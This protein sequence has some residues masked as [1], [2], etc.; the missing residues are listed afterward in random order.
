MGSEQRAQL[1]DP[2]KLPWFTTFAVRT[3]RQVFTL[4]TLLIIYAV[5]EIVSA[6]GTVGL[7]LGV[8]TVESALPPTCPVTVV[9]PTALFFNYFFF[10]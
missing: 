9:L 1:R 4:Y 5:F 8:P 3:S 7:S 6:Y 2:D 10:F